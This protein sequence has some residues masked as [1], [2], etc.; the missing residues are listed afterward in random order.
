MVNDIVHDSFV[1]DA[2]KEKDTIR[3]HDINFTTAS[4]AFFDPHRVIIADELH[5][6]TEPRLFCIGLVN[7]RVATV[8]FTYRDGKI[9][10]IGAGFWR[11]GR[12]IYE[13]QKR[14]G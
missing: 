12:K 2:Y 4:T 5:S 10:I 11:Q 8:R 14:N 7:K 6:T 9:R 1:W 13:A 3:R